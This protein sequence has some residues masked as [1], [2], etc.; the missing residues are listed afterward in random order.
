MSSEEDDNKA[1]A[2]NWTWVLG[3]AVNGI[4]PSDTMMC[5][6]LKGETALTFYD[7][8]VSPGMVCS[9]CFKF[10]RPGLFGQHA[11]D[12]MDYHAPSQF[13]VKPL[14]E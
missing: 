6:L 14:E 10:S 5:F 9:K 3:Y 1:T 11:K 13:H 12:N 4:F 8:I 2:N 7:K